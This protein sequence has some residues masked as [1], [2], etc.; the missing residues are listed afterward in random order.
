[1]IISVVGHPASG[2]DTVADYIGTLGFKKFSS[3]DFIRADMKTLGIPEDRTSMNTFASDM[4]KKFGN[5]YPAQE[6]I[7]VIDGNTV[8]A[9]FRNTE[10]I[11]KFHDTFNDKFKIIATEAPIEIRYQWA[12]ERGRIGDNISLEQFIQEEEKERSQSSG[13]HEVD[14][15]INMADIVLVNDGTKEDLFKKVDGILEKLKG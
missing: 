2:K 12:K 11:K 1:M 8:I 7:N 5:S 10:E 13:S 9:G 15:V 14:A 6:I 3:G 4:R